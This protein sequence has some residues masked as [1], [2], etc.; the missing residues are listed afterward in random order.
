MSRWK[1]RWVD[2]LEE[3][4]VCDDQEENEMDGLPGGE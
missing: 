2:D 3:N 1:I 4:E